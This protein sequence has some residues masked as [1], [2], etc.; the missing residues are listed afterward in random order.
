MMKRTRF[1][2]GPTRI[3][4]HLLIMGGVTVLT[5]GTPV[6]LPDAAPRAFAQARDI[7]VYINEKP[8]TFSG[9]RPAR[10]GGRVMVPM[11]AIFEGLGAQVAWDPGTQGINAQRA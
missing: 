3:T 1:K 2:T 5:F 4:S 8:L 7:G 10:I 9:A 6:V 11:R